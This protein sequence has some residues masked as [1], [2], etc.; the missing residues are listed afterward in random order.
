MFHRFIWIA[1]LLLFLT[2]L[3][4]S[5]Q[6]EPNSCT[7]AGCCCNV[8]AGGK[9]PDC[10]E[11]FE[12]RGMPKPPYISV[13]VKKGSPPQTPLFLASNQPAECKK[14]ESEKS[15]ESKET[16]TAASGKACHGEGCCCQNQPLG[17]WPDCDAGFEC[18]QATQKPYYKVCVKKGAPANKTLQI[19][20][21]QPAQ[22]FQRYDS[23]DPSKPGKGNFLCENQ[24]DPQAREWCY[25][26]MVNPPNIPGSGKK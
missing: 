19:A 14:A 16:P 22:C 6:T 5:A 20:S 25:R 8:Q 11:G 18:R 1:F 23:G 10:S 7:G 17:Q 12:C 26:H 21:N 15:E 24:P 9:W 4:A 3:T 13:C 2:P